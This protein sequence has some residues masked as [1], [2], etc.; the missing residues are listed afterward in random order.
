[1]AAR[2]LI[3]G[4]V[5]CHP[6][7]PEGRGPEPAVAAA[8]A[9][10]RRLTTSEYRHTLVDLF[11]DD[12]ILPTSLEPD[13]EVDGLY[14]VGAAQAALSP[15]GVEQYEAAAYFVASQVLE[16]PARRAAIV[17]CTPEGTVDDACT[18]AFVRAIGRRAWRR[19]LTDA[20]VGGL[21]AIGATASQTLGDFWLG[22]EYPLAALLQSPH[23]VYRVEVGQDGRFTSVELATRLSYLLWAGPPDD[24]L[25]DLAEQ[26]ALLDPEVRGS[27]AERMLQD[28]RAR[29]GLREHFDQWFALHDV[30]ELVKD[31]V[32]YV[33]WSDGI[34][35]AARE[36]TLSTLEWMVFDADDG[37]GG[38]VRDLLTTRTTF[39]DRSLAALYEVAAPARDGFAQTELPAGPRAGLLG[40]AS[41]LALQAH[42]TSTSVTRRGKFVRTRLL[43]HEIPPPPANVDTS[44]PAPSADAPTMR[45][46]VAD[47]LENPACSSCHLVTDPMGLAFEQFDG[48]GRYRTT[49]ADAVIDPSGDLD[50]WGFADAR[51]LE[52]LLRHHQ[53][54]PRCWT[55]SAVAYASGV[56]PGDDQAALGQWYTDGLAARGY[57]WRELL[58]DV[59]G[60]DA[61]A[62]A[63]EAP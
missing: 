2:W 57:R 24:A 12:L 53:D 6:A 44:I 3:L 25:L 4:V 47:H 45:D 63:G 9:T 41:F 22:L 19:T 7:D 52:E 27:E 23:F 34:G 43:C 21:V 17:P 28:P 11:G 37:A 61:F 42:S 49:E 20:E 54:L 15:L 59:I 16:D 31:P 46:R 36:E 13:L 29:R 33:H 30:P 50:G 8:P 26:G 48:I 62:V 40:Q 58:L 5:A 14:E 18:E 56:M 1:M 10:L 39:L 35:E 38:D 51:E 32:L 55:D 60:S